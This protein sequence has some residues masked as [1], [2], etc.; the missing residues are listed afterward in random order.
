MLYQAHLA[1]AAFELTNLV[2]VGLVWFMAFNA[3]FN[4]ISDIS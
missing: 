2:V 1:L 4:S 3:T